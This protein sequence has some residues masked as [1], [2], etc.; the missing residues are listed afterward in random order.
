MKIQQFHS[1]S[2]S[3]LIAGLAMTILSLFSAFPAHGEVRSGLWMHQQ[4]S[5]DSSSS[6]IDFSERQWPCSAPLST[7]KCPLTAIDCSFKLDSIIAPNG[8]YFDSTISATILAQLPSD[9]IAHRG[10]EALFYIDSVMKKVSLTAPQT[11]VKPWVSM[12]KSGV[13]FIK[14]KE[15]RYAVM[16]NCGTT[17]TAIDRTLYYWAYQTDSTATLFKNR[18]SDQPAFLSI[19]VVAFSGRPDP[20]FRLTDSASIAAI[21]HQLNVSVNFFLDSTIKR[22]DSLTCSSVLGYSKL[23]VGAFPA[24]NPV[25]S[26]APTIDI[27]GGKINYYKASSSSPLRYYDKDSRLEKLIIRLCCQANL[28]DTDSYGTIN[29]CDIVPDSLKPPVAT[30]QTE[31][32][33]GIDKP[34]IRC[35]IASHEIQMQFIPEGQFSIDCFSLS[36]KC[37]ATIRQNTSGQNLFSVNLRDYSIGVGAYIIKFSHSSSTIKTMIFPVFIYR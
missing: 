15:N 36:G 34:T 26:Y 11:G 35:R 4:P 20:Y 33:H 14:T 7:G 18:L 28:S 1:C 29:F 16:V 31:P 17:A 2:P 22:A 5:S 32:R 24:E 30:M 23:S 25:S 21:M 8:I 3:P 37:L 19:Y 6:Y 27:C 13:F 12:Q 10:G 9:L